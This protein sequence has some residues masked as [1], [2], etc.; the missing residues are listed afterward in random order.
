MS[1]SIPVGSG[2]NSRVLACRTLPNPFDQSLAIEGAI[3]QDINDRGGLQAIC[4]GHRYDSPPW[5]KMPPQGKRFLKIA[6]QNIAVIPNDGADHVMA[7]NQ[8]PFIMWDGYDGCI[9]TVIFQ[10]TGQGFVEGSG[11]LTWRI[12]INER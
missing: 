7:F 5:V 4:P 1:P 3:W 2:Y 10:F 12:Q 6:T 11:D 9:D 8:G